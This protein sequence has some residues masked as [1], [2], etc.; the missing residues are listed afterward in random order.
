MEVDAP[1]YPN[2]GSELL[3]NKLEGDDKQSTF[4]KQTLLH[5]PIFTNIIPDF[6]VCINKKFRGLHSITVNDEGDQYLCPQEEDSQ[7]DV[8]SDDDDDLFF[9]IGEAPTGQTMKSNDNSTNIKLVPIRL[10]FKTTSLL[11]NDVEFSFS[12]PVRSSCALRGVADNKNQEEDSLLISLKSGFLFLIRIY[13]VPR[14]YKDT[15]YDF[16]GQKKTKESFIFKP[17]IVQWWD[18][19]GEIPVP[20]L[21]T[22]GYALF[23]HASGLSAVS[24]SASNV[25]RIF[26]CQHTDSGIMFMPHFNVPVDGIILHSCFV[27][28][29]S[30]II[31]DNHV[32]FLT[33]IFTESRRLE[34]NLYA[35]TLSE[36]VNTNLTKTI[37][38]LDNSFKIPVFIISLG[39]G[40]S[41]LLVTEEE[42]IIVTIHDILSADYGFTRVPYPGSFPTNYYRP[43]SLI[44]S[45]T[46]D[47]TDEVLISTDN[48]VIYSIIIYGNKDIQILPITRVSDPIS[49]FSFERIGNEFALI[50]GSDTG[51][52][53]ELII[54]LLFTREYLDSLS[55]IQKP[56]YSSVQLI[57]DFKNWAPILD[58]LIIDS[59]RSR[60]VNNVSDQ[61]LWALTG[62]GKRTRLTRLRSGY[63][64]TRKSMTYEQ[65]RKTDKLHFIELR[66]KYY[67]FCSLP[68]E[69]IVLEYQTDSNEYLIEIEDA[70]LDTT[71]FSLLVANIPADPD[72]LIQITQNSIT[73]T[74]LF[75]SYVSTELGDQNILFCDINNDYLGI[76]SESSIDKLSITMELLRFN[77]NIDYNVDFESSGAFTILNSLK[78]PYQPSMMRIVE[79][80]SLTYVITGSYDGSLFIYNL[81]SDSNLSLVKQYALHDFNPYTKKGSFYENFVIPHDSIQNTKERSNIFVGSR[82]GYYIH[83]Q[84]QA[85]AELKCKIFLK[86]GDTPVL[87]KSMHNESLMVFVS[88]RSLW[89]LNLFESEYLTQVFFEERHDRAISAMIQLPKYSEGGKHEK[90]VKYFGFVREEGFTIGSVSTFKGPNIKQI[91]I[92]ESGKKLTYLPHLSTFVVLCNSKDPKFRMKFIDRKLCKTL[93]HHELNARLKILNS[94]EAIFD[95]NE[96]P[97]AA[98]IWSIKR[99]ERISK[100]L[101]V[102]SM[103]NN[104][105]GS[106]KVL[107][108]SKEQSSRE[109]P[110]NIRVTELTSFDHKEPITN[111]QQIDTAILFSSGRTIYSTTYDIDERKLK[112]VASLL[113]LTSEIISLS[114]EEENKLLVTTKLDSIFQFAYS[115][116]PDTD[117][118][119]LNLIYKDLSPKSIVNQ[120]HLNNKVIAGDKL[121]S[122]I[123]IMDF[124]ENT[125]RNRLSYK[126][127]SIP[128]VYASRFNSYWVDQGNNEQDMNENGNRNILCVGVNGEITSIR[129]LSKNSIELD[130]LAKSLNLGT[131]SDE[132][133]ESFM[134][135]LNRPFTDKVTGK[136]LC[137]INKP[138]FNYRDNKGKFI[139]FDLD[140]ISKVC[141]INVSL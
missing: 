35:W 68:F 114:I 36:S 31:I 47:K 96:I 51:S 124:Y 116:N 46:D 86:I 140:E 126:M 11:V 120:A 55:N 29:L 38:P 5:S 73:I 89:L 1:E 85:N 49:V 82:D 44:C 112:P 50:F 138:H 91:N 92:A 88:S 102:G 134:E 70:A 59:F 37:L 58:I 10:I 87:F 130:N 111:I 83:F 105:S 4:I 123:L 75:D 136:G 128:R 28:P 95:V 57:R 81:T 104:T 61:E 52:N 141:Q 77:K 19:S 23:T 118:D 14:T 32:M 67:L 12:A 107:D 108:I 139:D 42:L 30:N 93:Q 15:D 43:S 16:Q 8:F 63:S 84:F 132:L 72:R 79:I 97:T 21:D 56:N 99:Q 9:K 110:V 74:N 103:V 100:K 41:F 127:P 113:T 39:N 137:S 80:D 60:T 121:H 133:I 98:C 135:K 18:T 7:F 25:F 40:D 26:N 20:A 6:Q 54:S 53:R 106:F 24:T 109:H 129:S 69:T 94:D 13:Y 131:M 17:F 62:T 122:S 48:G 125:L 119:T 90:G 71:R 117:T 34:L 115:K 33:M 45:S 22:S 78:I 65:L 76:I 27:E 64:A 2:I 66:N 101:L 3:V